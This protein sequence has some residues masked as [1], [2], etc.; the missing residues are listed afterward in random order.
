M[1]D[2]EELNLDELDD[3]NGGTHMDADGGIDIGSIKC[4]NCGTSHRRPGKKKSGGSIKC[5]CGAYYD[6][7]RGTWVLP[8]N[9]IGK[10]FS[11][12]VNT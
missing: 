7:V 12:F 9:E 8:K 1:K 2:L 6:L 11:N 4:P 10:S 5:D 3:V